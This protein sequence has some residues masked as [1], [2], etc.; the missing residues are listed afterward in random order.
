[1]NERDKKSLFDPERWGLPLERIEALPGQLRRHWERF[2]DCFITQTR[3]TSEHAYQY[4]RGQMTMDKDRTYAGI[5]RT[6]ENSD[7]QSIQHFMSNSPW[8]GQEVFERIQADICAT[9]PLAQGSLLILDE[10]AD[11]KADIQSAGAGRQY[12]GR[13]GKVDTCQVSVVL[14]Y[15]NWH[16]GPWTT[17][18]L[19]DSALFLPEEWF[20]LDFSSLCQ[21]LGV[22][23][24]RQFETKPQLA[25]K[26][27]RRAKAQGL[28]FE[29]VACDDFYRRDGHF[30]ADLERE[31]EVYFDDEPAHAH[32]YVKRP[33]I[34]VP[35]KTAWAGRPKSKVRV[36]NQVKSIRV[37]QAGGEPDTEW[38]RLFIR[39]NERGVLEDEFA[40]RRV[41]TWT[42]GESEVREEWLILRIKRNGERTYTLSNAL[43]N[44]S[45]EH[46]AEWSCGRYFVER[47][48]QDAKDENGWDEFQAQKYFGWEHIIPP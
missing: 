42:K 33:V 21:K 5:A 6:L 37:D 2:R 30:R 35:E 9:L 28:P 34:G 12:N 22:P 24:E 10:S 39:H 1:L 46:L 45:L 43:I 15:A 14:G 44:T 7:G 25:L 18:T 3:D 4:L 27:I 32:V 13:L 41:W 47:V 11:E 48:I 40:A 26:M 36:L 20:T 23:K 17:W 31:G 8:S 29:A 19:V 16:S 38:Q